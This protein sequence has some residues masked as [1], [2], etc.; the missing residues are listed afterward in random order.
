MIKSLS[1]SLGGSRTPSVRV[2]AF[3]K[4]P[5]WDDHIDDVGLST[6][7]LVDA[8]RTLYADCIAGCIDSGSWGAPDQPP[9]AW[10]VDYG[11]VFVW[12]PEGMQGP[13]LAGRLWPSR[14]GRRRT[15][16]PMV[17]CAQC[18]GVGLD[19]TA[20]VVLPRLE[21]LQAACIEATEQSQV[22]EAVEAAGRELQELVSN[23]GTADEPGASRASLDQLLSSGLGEGS[24]AAIHRVQYQFEREFGGF[25]S[26]DRPG[27]GTLPAR[28]QH[29][30]VP[31]AVEP[32]AR[33]IVAWT[34]YFARQLMTDAPMLV[35]APFQSGWVD[36]AVGPIAPQLIAP[37][38]ANIEQAP[39]ASEVPYTISEAFARKV[40]AMLDG[41][42]GRT[43]PLAPASTAAAPSTP[44][45]TSAPTL[46]MPANSLPS[47]AT[48]A[49]ALETFSGD[50]GSQKSSGKWMGVAIA[51]GVLVIAIVIAAASGLFS[52]GGGA[53][54]TQA[55]PQG[56]T[57]PADKPT[58][59]GATSTTTPGGR[60]AGTPTPSTPDAKPPTPGAGSPNA[61]AVPVPAPVPA[62]EPA[63][64]DPRA[65]ASVDAML[66]SAGDR[67][68]SLA[69]DVATP[70][71]GELKALESEAKAV[72]ALTLSRANIEQVRARV[73]ALRKNVESVVTRADASAK[74]AASAPVPVPVP[75]AP[76]PA[77]A[78]SGVPEQLSVEP[79]LNEAW[80]K[81]VSLV[82]GLQMTPERTARLASMREMI[83][84][85]SRGLPTPESLDLP[86]GPLASVVMAEFKIRRQRAVSEGVQRLDQGGSDLEAV[87][88]R[89]AGLASEVSTW[90]TASVGLARHHAQ[91][92]GLLRSGA[93]W[94]D[95][96]ERA[97]KTLA[98]VADELRVKPVAPEFASAFA[99]VASQLDS[100]RSLAGSS[101]RAALMGALLSGKGDL[102]PARSASDRLAELTP[103]WPASIEELAAVATARGSLGA[104]D[105]PRTKR[106]N[107]FVRTAWLQQW[108][109]S[110][111]VAPAGAGDARRAALMEMLPGLGIEA[112]S[113]PAW[114]SFNLARFELRLGLERLPKRDDASARP[115]IERYATAMAMLMPG[116][117]EAT[118]AHS[119]AK[120]LLDT[121][122]VPKIGPADFPPALGGVGRA[123][124]IPAGEPGD[125]GRI[126][127]SLSVP[128]V[129]A[130]TLAFAP[131]EVNGK[132]VYVSTTEISVGVAAGVLGSSTKSDV[133]A[134]R[135]QDWNRFGTRRGLRTWEPLSKT[136]LAAG[137]PAL[138]PPGG[139]SDPLRGWFL[140]PAG[141]DRA[142]GLLAVPDAPGPQWNSPMQAVSPEAAAVVAAAMNCRLPTVDEW[143]AA[144]AVEGL[145]GA[146]EAPAGAQLRGRQWKKQFDAVR[147][148]RAA[149]INLGFP[150]D[151]A[152]V[153]AGATTPASPEADDEALPIDEPSFLMAPV[154][155]GPG[156][157]FKHLIGNVWEWVLVDGAKFERL[158]PDEIKPKSIS[159]ASDVRVV[160]G[161]ALS[162][163]TISRTQPQTAVA[164]RAAGGFTDVGFRVAFSAERGLPKQVLAS[165]AEALLLKASQDAPYRE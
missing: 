114:A 11:H 52:S 165:Q 143:R 122:P 106:L 126:A 86:G 29:I 90:S 92:E 137:K 26:N 50:A 51:G 28:G 5:A 53:A 12:Y 87:G 6:D 69:P 83:E 136:P 3:G 19:W 56:G 47:D 95:R 142:P 34:R 84:A 119:A 60:D 81:Q 113:L 159:P 112:K 109:T 89:L 127:Y 18:E 15:K 155:V 2:S 148:A 161:S 163:P 21:K 36:V 49:P 72:A 108:G 124:W 71:K 121:P 64:I 117:A 46:A 40:E 45:N 17:L 144:L 111:D 79:A 152:F 130:L 10:L 78:V 42:Q 54:G 149:S 13:V 162:S 33:A 59:S 77:A 35:A 31:S 58:T 105:A 131:V 100:V 94:N 129:P 4:H 66:D 164:A 43:S 57:P 141:A 145:A 151:G 73:A 70:L 153:P 9:P 85:F 102:S 8:R 118:A 65:S 133:F 74:A 132:T 16:F 88:T 150:Q 99:G 107:D 128:G 147:A 91:A 97:G 32:P 110:G 93:A 146:D 63:L 37:L 61:G 68:A 14:D 125:D 98:Q 27:K 62:E 67:V 82:R 158:G 135:T 22:I 55:N 154:D 41:W 156:K 160:G 101:D 104:L 20:R 134:D 39:P 157:T 7:E 76:A 140:K 75:V 120:A 115:L 30:R 123:K 24:R 38:R 139:A 48:P 1:K 23:A 116:L 44:V 96:D 25:L 80:A 138:G 103:A